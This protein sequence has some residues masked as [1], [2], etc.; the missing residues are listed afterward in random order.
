MFLGAQ[1]LFY[2]GDNKETVI[3]AT[4]AIANGNDKGA[5]CKES[6]FLLIMII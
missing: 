5:P 1:L 6:C 3:L 2:N 4:D